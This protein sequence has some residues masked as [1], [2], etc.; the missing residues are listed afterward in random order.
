MTLMKLRLDFYFN[1]F[2]NILE[3][4]WWSLHSSF[5]FMGMGKRVDVKLSVL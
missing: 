1:I 2:L 5:L 3:Y 4:I